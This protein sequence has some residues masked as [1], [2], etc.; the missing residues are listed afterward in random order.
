[1]SDGD[2]T[3]SAV[4]D[5]CPSCACEGTTDEQVTQGLVRNHGSLSASTKPSQPVRKL[6]VKKNQIPES[7]MQNDSLRK[8]IALLPENYNFEIEKS[9]WRI[10]SS[11]ASCVAL[12]FPEGLLHYACIIA[13]IFERFCSVTTIILGD[14]TYGACC[15]DDI[16]ASKLGADLL[17]HYGHSCLVPIHS[18]LLPVMYVFVA[19]SFDHSHL[20]ACIAGNFVADERLALMGTIQFVNVLHAAKQDLEAKHGFKGIVIPQATPLSMGE[21]LGCTSAT[22]DSEVLVFVADGRFHLESA[23]IMNPHVV[24]YRY[25]PYSKT[26]TKEM[27]ETALMK[28]TRFQEIERARSANEFGL[29]LGTLGRQ[30]SI[31]I[32]EKLLTLLRQKHK[33]VLLFLMS[34]LN[35]VKMAQIPGIEAWVQVACPR[36]SIDW[37]TDFGRPLLTPYEAEVA[38]GDTVWKEVYPMDY[39]SSKPKT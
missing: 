22:I 5:G 35:S 4:P 21:T 29:I 25:D 28:A 16:T 15:V 18:S 33:R 9:V 13:D 34:E 12:Q 30:G 38:L 7:V 37:G 2:K 19:I 39:Y 23:M 31:P 1:M 32:F 8:A 26:L 11:K 14:V 24:S 36:L 3:C 6:K 10:C 27:Y 17:I 20:V